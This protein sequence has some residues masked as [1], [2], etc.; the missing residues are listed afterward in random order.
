[1]PSLFADV[2]FPDR[3]SRPFTYRIPQA[4]SGQLKV[5]QWVVAPLGSQTLAGFILSLS[6]QLAPTWP[7]ASARKINIRELQDVL[8]T[9]S[10]F[11][12]DPILIE[13]AQWISEYYLA[14]MGL[15]LQLIQPPRLPGKITSRITITEDGLAAIPSLRP[16]TNGTKLLTYLVKK[17]KGV[18]RVTLRNIVENLDPALTRLKRQ[19]WLNESYSIGPFR[20]TTDPGGSSIPR[21]EIQTPTA[22]KSGEEQTHLFQ[23]SLTLSSSQQRRVSENSSEPLPSWWDT[24]QHGIALPQFQEFLVS[25]PWARDLNVLFQ[26]VEETLRQGKSALLV[27]PDISRASEIAQ[28][29]RA[30]WG[31][32]V[33]LFHSGLPEATKQARW[34]AMSR[35]QFKIVVGTRMALFVPMPSLGLINLEDEDDS[36]YKEEQCPY[37]H[38]RE[39]ARQRAVLSGA[40][41]FFQSRHPS[42]ETYAHFVSSDEA[43]GLF[44]NQAPMRKPEIHVV[45]LRQ[46]SYGTILS[47]KMLHAVELGLQA[48]GGIVFYINRKG[49]SSSL[50][51]QDCGMGLE[52]SHC[53]VSL[54]MLKPPPRLVCSYCGYVGAVPISCPACSSPRLEPAGFGTERVEEELRKHFPTTS[55]ARLDRNAFG[56]RHADTA[57]REKFRKGEI[58]ILVGTQM[59]FHGEPLTPVRFMGIPYAESGLH[60]PDFRAAEYLYQHLQQAIDLVPFE[61]GEGKVVLQTRL[62]TH[63][64]IEAVVQQNPR[65][66][67]EHELSMRQA[68][69]YPPTTQLTQLLVSGTQPNMTQDIAS[70]LVNQLALKLTKLSTAA[71]SPPETEP[72]ILGPILR[73]GHR[74]TKRHQ[75][76]IL[77]K[78]QA[79]RLIGPLVK[80]TLNELK[81][82][83][84]TK[85]ILF[86]VNVDPVDML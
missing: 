46:T 28:F 72:M 59:L 65:L 47:Q 83:K 57:I 27:S 62:P 61:Y 60:M 7:S 50:L 53:H 5:G 64:A 45:D 56:A 42:L 81:S 71:S 32:Q 79:S 80:D 12:L 77:I 29:F 22:R 49:F 52:C 21:T 82:D 9:S 78:A 2:V 36:S 8:T 44:S 69:G 66:F 30:E 70:Q 35:G 31:D 51:C 1:M 25:N 24:F 10:D 74:T 55:I 58:A 76:Q 68:M 39:V 34:V 18:T 73:R 14:P 75:Y 17:P 13:L 20:S 63:H 43:S 41:I 85:G 67:Y 84:S 19:G 4:L 37:Y 38:A 86:G 54:N 3:I 16:S 33:G 6:G 11:E 23:T 15:C 26:A 48:G 40:T